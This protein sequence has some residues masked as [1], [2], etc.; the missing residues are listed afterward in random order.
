MD[1]RILIGVLVG[2]VLLVVVV[3][4]VIWKR[5]E[6]FTK[7]DYNA[8]LLT[9]NRLSDNSMQAGLNIKNTRAL[10]LAVIGR[11]RY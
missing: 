9:T 6:K 8:Y 1:E 2:V 11:T 3:A 4:G 5:K 7:P 10:Q